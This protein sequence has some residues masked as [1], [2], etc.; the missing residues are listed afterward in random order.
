VLVDELSLGLAPVVVQRLVPVIQSV[1][2]SGVG[3]LLIEQFA[4]VALGLAETA[5]VLERGRIHYHGTAQRLKDEPE[6]LQSA[7]LLRDVDSGGDAL[8]TVT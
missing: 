7:Y 4:N 8:E 3:V 5:Y 6:L 2:A 1:A